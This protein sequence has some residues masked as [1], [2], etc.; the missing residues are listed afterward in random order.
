MSL[1][2][3]PY[4]FYPLL[5]VPAESLEDTNESVDVGDSANSAESTDV[6][7]ASEAIRDMIDGTVEA[8]DHDNDDDD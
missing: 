2:F 7:A 4:L 6:P 8:R 3:F 5:Q 1:L